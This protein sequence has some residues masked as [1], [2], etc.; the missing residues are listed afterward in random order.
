MKIMMMNP[1]S[2]K[3]AINLYLFI[4]LNLMM[5]M[6]MNNDE[7]SLLLTNNQSLFRRLVQRDKEG[8][9]DEPDCLQKAPISTWTYDDDY[10]DDHHVV[11]DDELIGD[12]EPEGLRC[13]MFRENEDND[14]A[15]AIMELSTC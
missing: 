9:Y 15:L 5:V 1:A 11:D 14:G 3:Q 2:Y 4:L 10:H 6:I 8:G 12:C 7:P 13:A